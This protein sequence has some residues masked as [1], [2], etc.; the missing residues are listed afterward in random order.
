[1]TT[2]YAAL[3]K[4]PVFFERNRVF[5]VY[6]GGKLFAGFFGDE[7][8]DG[9]LPEEWIA[10][11]VKALNRD[12]TDPDE[13]LSVIRG[14]G[15]KFADLLR[16]EPGLTLGK[17]GKSGDLGV[18][19]KILDSAIRLPIQA[20]PDKRFSRKHFGSDYGKTEMWLV[21]ATRPDARIYFGFDRKITKE[22]F[23]AAVEASADDR[24][25]MTGLLNEVKVEPG[26]VY[27]IPAR[28]VHAIGFG[29]LI[30]EVQEPTDFTIQPEHWCGNY[31]LNDYEMY[32]GLPKDVALDC[33]D[34]DVFGPESV[35][36]ARKDPKTLVSDPGAMLESLIGAEDSPC[37]SV[38][39]LTVKD[40]SRV[41]DVTPCVCIVVSGEGGLTGPAGETAIR[42]GDYFFMP[43]S[44]RG[45][46]RIASES[47]IQVVF[48]HPPV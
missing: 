23:S 12:S 13:G 45:Q 15:V 35:A 32:L 9:N 25:A 36:L 41:I 3:A 48:C 34:F 18:L 38:T 43:L 40:S 19:V 46:Y 17:G 1:M 4:K 22:R 31:R 27:L 7:P 30:L 14:T 39:R 2:D 47:G 44:T 37:F 5:R 16:Q 26:E 21:L 20:H 29:C 11:S 10:S 24:Q 6:E 8:V 33:F 28:T 42:K